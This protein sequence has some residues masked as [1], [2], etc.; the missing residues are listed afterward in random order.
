MSYR[1]HTKR[2]LS[3]STTASTLFQ[4]EL[5]YVTARHEQKNNFVI[6]PIALRSLLTI[7]SISVIREP[8]RE[9]LAAMGMKSS[10]QGVQEYKACRNANKDEFVFTI[11][12]GIY[13][14]N[15][16]ELDMSFRTNCMEQFQTRPENLD[17]DQLD[18]VAQH[19]N[20]WI[21]EQTE[22]RIRTR[23]AAD[24]LDVTQHNLLINIA[25]FESRWK[26]AFP[27]KFL[28]KSEFWL[29]PNDKVEVPMMHDYCDIPVGDLDEL[30]ATA[31]VLPH[32]NINIKLIILVPKEIDG[33][34]RLEEKLQQQRIDITVLP[35]L[36]N[37]KNV[38]VGMP[39]IKLESNMLM[40]DILKEVG[41]RTIFNDCI[42]FT[43]LL[44]AFNITKISQIR[45]IAA[46]EINDDGTNSSSSKVSFLLT[47]V[48]KCTEINVNRPFFFA[49][50]DTE[51]VYFGGHI[52]NTRNFMDMS[53]N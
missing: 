49:V 50:I 39:R 9:V 30:R 11:H 48:E 24:T 20:T 32:R 14:D 7:I 38:K 23:I 16:F 31:L 13:L 8:H 22:D 36:L 2:S 12:N 53:T 28:M 10:H 44:T 52:T 1:A 6:S 46:I 34:R 37:V 3:S 4:S 51:R 18:G 45:H 42:D 21:N 41:I 33:L 40:N 17:F 43:R 19:I 35:S 26:K 5:L 29:T 27:K 15:R 47:E 25:R